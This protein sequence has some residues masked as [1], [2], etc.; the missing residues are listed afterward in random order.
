MSSSILGYILDFLAGVFIIQSIIFRSQKHIETET[1][2]V[3]DG[4]PLLHESQIKAF[5]DGWIGA[6]ILF[7]GLLLHIIHFEISVYIGAL[8]VSE[9]LLILVLIHLISK[10]KIEA[11]MSKRYG[12]T[13]DIVKKRAKGLLDA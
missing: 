9:I 4:N 7:A 5:R 2:P 6:L 11:K 3:W 8:I 10:R 12:S 13:Y 1:Q